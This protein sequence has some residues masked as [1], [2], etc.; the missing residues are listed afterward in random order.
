MSG[1]TRGILTA[2]GLLLLAALGAT[3]YFWPRG[4]VVPEIST[5][6]LDREVAE[7]VREAHGAVVQAPWSADAWGHLG[8]VL[9]ANEIEPDIAMACFENAERLDPNNPRWPYLFAG[10]LM[11]DKA[12]PEAALPKLQRATD[13]SKRGR[14]VPSAVRLRLAETLALLGCPEEAA[15]HFVQVQTAEPNN[16][17]AHFGLALLALSRGD[18]Q[19]SRVHLEACLGSPQAR[20]KA[21]VQLV[22]VCERLKDAASAEK[23]AKL[24]RQMPPDADW[25]DPYVLEHVHL[26]LRRQSKINR[27]ELLESAGRFEQAVQELSILTRNDPD[28]YLLYL[29]LG[30]VLPRLPGRLAEAERHLRTAHRLAPDKAAELQVHYLLSLVLYYKA[31]AMMQ[32]GGE[33]EQYKRVFEEAAQSARAALAIRKDYGYAHMAL[34]LAL[35]QL[36]QSKEALAAFREAVHCNPEYADNH[37]FLG[38]ALAAEKQ[39]A[40]ARVHLEQARLLALPD[41]PRPRQALEKL[42]K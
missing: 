15:P 38:E 5:D 20:K 2:A 25:H 18:D 11:V 19:K 35:K 24:A 13:L 9:L 22:A 12:N 33:P 32:G 8:R 23:Y 21:C 42:P 31:E 30:R 10:Y 1:R 34:G 4:P 40:E 14:D 29:M 6:R 16:P 3:I 26:A 36:G 17:R 41:D 39:F 28:N 27:I 37:L 7:L